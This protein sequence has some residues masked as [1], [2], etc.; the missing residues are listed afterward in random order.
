MNDK[1]TPREQ[2]WSQY[3][4]VLVGGIAIALLLILLVAWTTFSEGDC[5]TYMRL[6]GTK[7]TVCDV[8]KKGT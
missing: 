4:W 1:Q 8:G 6:D 7:T 3:G 5:R 2:F